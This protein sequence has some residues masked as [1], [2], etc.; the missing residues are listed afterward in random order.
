MNEEITASEVSHATSWR[1]FWRHFL[2]MVVAMV[3]GMALLGVLSRLV[4]TLLGHSNLL[5]QTE[6]RTI[7][8]A[9]NM[10]VGMSLWM[11]Y[12]GHTWVSVG[13]MAGAMFL[14]F[15]VLLVP[16][17]TGKL[18]GDAVSAGGHVLML[19]LMVA[20]M[21]RR[22]DEYARDHRRSAAREGQPHPSAEVG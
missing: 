9:T 2:E 5:D 20:V 13:E 12:R 6:L 8:M 10:T 4:L 22:R 1:H 11:R 14:P 17:W 7:L 21:L 18:S 19:P 16:F 15:V 3:A